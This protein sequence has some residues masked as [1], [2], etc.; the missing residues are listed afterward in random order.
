MSG[1]TL[2]V[3]DENAEVLRDVERELR[4]RYARHY[5]V[6]SVAS[7]HEAKGCLD[8]LAADGEEVALV[9]SGQWL[10]GM[11]GSELLAH[12]RR[13]HPHAKR[14]LLIEWGQWGDRET[15]EAI[16]DGIA[17]GRIDHYL[18]R[19]MASPD[20]VFHQAV[21]GLLLE[22]SEARRSSPYTIHVVGESWSGRAYE[23]RQ[24]LGRCAIPHAFCL[25]DSSEG[26]AHIAAAGVPAE[27]PIVVFPNGTV[28]TNPSD[29]DIALAA[30]SPVNPERTEFDLVIV[31]A[32]PAGLSAA[33]YGASEGFST[34]VVD[35]GGLGGQATSSSLIRNYL[36]FPR[37]VSGRRLAQRAYDQAWVFGAKFA[38]MQ[39]VTGL[40]RE[41]G[42]LS[43]TL[44]TGARVR[45]RAVLLATGASYHRLGV[46]ALEALN[47]AGVFYGGPTSEAPAMC[48]RDVY[49]LGGGNSAGQAAL[50]LARYAPS[51]TIVVR[52]RSL[53]DG[54]SHY[55]VRE[56]E[57]TPG[58]RV[59]TATE[60]VGGGGNGRLEHLVLRDRVT[61]SE[62]TVGADG[63]FVLIGARPHTG[64]LPPEVGR[65]AQ[66]FVLTGGDLGEGAWPLERDPLPLETS[67]PGVFAAG[68]ARHGSVKRVASAVGEGSVAIQLLHR[69]FAAHELLPRGHVR[70]PVA[71]ATG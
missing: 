46:P 64:W 29:A 44:S 9:L 48:G 63:L 7:S 55:L 62:E 68:D 31:G 67:L 47:G 24:V 11:T 28:L 26:R 13:L 33:M 57:A 56:A 2:V 50:Y 40:R 54:M 8:E 18:L 1:A 36:G 23:L 20:E 43:V 53:G 10:S 16:F 41:H 61:G 71:P 15:G 38:F 52:G 69:M 37:G 51:V 65:D 70:E 3:V 14:G 39:K 32:G 25:A 30:G 49:V 34:L 42:E 60:I 35:E 6:V 22:W 27:L 45:S 21:S 66:G 19:P 17:R 12:V 5:R 59:R 4:E 58:V